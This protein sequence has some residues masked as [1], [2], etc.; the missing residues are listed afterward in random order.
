MNDIFKKYN[1]T[2]SDDEEVFYS[3]KIIVVFSNEN[4]AYFFI[5]CDVLP[6]EAIDSYIDWLYFIES[7]YG[8]ELINGGLFYKIKEKLYFDDDALNKYKSDVEWYIISKNN[9]EEKADYIFKYTREKDI[10]NC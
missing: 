8:Y 9:M 5:H 7:E 1:I 6:D 3:D 2:I 4:A 10:P